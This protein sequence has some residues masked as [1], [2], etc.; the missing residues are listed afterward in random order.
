MK[1]LILS[2]PLFLAGTHSFAQQS[3][4][5]NELSFNNVAATINNNGTFFNQ[6]GT[7]GPGYEVPKN[8]DKHAIYF[9]NF[10]TMSIDPNGGAKG[11]LSDYE[12]SDFSPG[13]IATD[14][15]DTNYVNRFSQSLW[16][17]DQATI[18]DHIAHWNDLGYVVPVE[19]ATWPANGTTANGE[20]H[21]L[22]PFT[23]LD[24]DLLY[25]PELGEYP[26]IRGDNAI[27]CILNDQ[28]A[29]HPSGSLPIGL[30]LHILF[31]QYASADPAIN[32]TTFIH[33]RWYNRGTQT[34][35]DFSPGSTIDFDL[36]N[37]YDDYF[38]TAPASNLA[39]VYNADLNDENFSVRPSGY[40]LYPPAVGIVALN[41][42]LTSHVPITSNNPNTTSVVEYYN[43]LSG[44]NHMGAPFYDNNN[45]ETVFLYN[46][47]GMGGWN[48][49]TE[50]LQAGDVRTIAGYG[51]GVLDNTLPP[52]T[53]FCLDVAV[54]Y[55]TNPGNDPFGSVM[56]LI[57]VTDS[58]Q[59]FYDTQDYSV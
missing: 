15:E 59:A 45:Q 38:G 26:T 4:Y 48:Q 23:D 53:S 36:G 7:Q 32:N 49:L 27:L 22:A 46:Q 24:G 8:S 20:S 18:N 30:E 9:M 19:I 51:T 1:H 43:L 33:S 29:V 17:I 16:E 44:N 21:I 28:A 52:L 39:Y 34:L 37:P 5:Y 35:A 10:M 58:V 40:G 55:A 57:A 42:G 56:E 12:S 13:P 3:I 41:T 25:E 47:E 11:A 31:Y 54:V 6:Y 50:G 14:Y 2:L